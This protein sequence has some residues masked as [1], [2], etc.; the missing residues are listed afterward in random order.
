LY[1][2]MPDNFIP[3]AAHVYEHNEI[4][5]LA[6]DSPPTKKKDY[7]WSVILQ[8]VWSMQSIMTLLEDDGEQH[9]GS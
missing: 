1:N 8:A 6:K 7:P 2:D 3:D 5:A 9:M 4:V